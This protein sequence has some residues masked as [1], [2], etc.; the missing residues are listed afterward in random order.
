[1][2]DWNNHRIQKFTSNGTF[3]AK[4]G[5][6]GG[7][8][9]QFQYPA[10]LAFDANGDIYVADWGNSRIQKFTDGGTF[11]S[12]WGSFGAGDGQFWG[13]LDVAIDKSEGT[14]YVADAN[15]DRIQ[16]LTVDG[17]FLCKW[18]SLGTGDGDFDWPNNVA[19]DE[20]G[21]NIY[22]LDG[23]NHRVQR[24]AYVAS[25]IG[26]IPPAGAFV[27]LNQ[28]RPNPFSESTTFQYQLPHPAIAMITIYDIRGRR[29]TRI[30]TA[31]Q[32]H[33][34]ITWNGLDDSG[35]KVASGIYFYRLQAGG[36]SQTKK[37]AILK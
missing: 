18:G 24:F 25:A 5:I 23:Y 34:A 22:V 12:T 1:V 10:G 15:N 30:V 13:P 11:L 37:M 3:I 9:A 14:I 17:I 16:K 27:L 20:S 8:N 31:V 29:V 6:W 26:E 21:D 32:A 4:W 35:R 19:V 36:F 28:N 7:G 33:G 2:S